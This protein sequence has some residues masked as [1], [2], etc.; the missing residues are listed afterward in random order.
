[1]P[2]SS[3]HRGIPEWAWLAGVLIVALALRLIYV[4]QV[5]RSTLVRPD[6]L[7][8]GF[9]YDWAKEIAS[10]NWLGHAPFVQSPLYAY[11]LA[12]L[13]KVFG[14]D[15]VRLLVV[16]A[17]AGCGTVL[18]TWYAGR[19]LL[20]PAHGL[21]AAGILA[22]YGP[23]I[24]FEGMVMKTFL[25]PPLTI[26]LVILFDRVRE[27]GAPIAAAGT[28][29]EP[30]PT[31]GAPAPAAGVPAPAGPAN[32][33]L[34]QAGATRLAGITGAVYGLATLD[35]DNFIL[36]APM[37][38]LL[39]LWLG[40]GPNRT[41]WRAAGAFT[42]GTVLVI[43]PVTL[44]N[45]IVA[46]EFVLL[47]TG[48]GE[49]FFIGNNADAN[50]LYVPPPFVRPDP[51]YEH[52]DF[53]SRASE[54]AGRPL[55]PMQSSWFWFRQ[56]MAFI[57]EHPLAWA[58]LL[59][60]KGVHFWN[61]YELPDNLNY[62][63]LQQFSPLLG[64][65]NAR[66]PPRGW[67]TLAL[68]LGAGRWAESRLHFYATF[69]T[70]APLGL[71]G[72]WLTRRGWRRLVPLYVLLFGYMGT[73]LLFFN[74]SRFRVPVVPI[75]ALFAAESL[76]VLGGG[77]RRA[78]RFALALL[79][80]SGDLVER[81]RALRP[82]ARQVAT[83]GL[84]AV[85]LLGLNLEL[86]RG[87]VP[88]IEEALLLGNAYYAEGQ[89]ETA[90][91]HYS[92][93]LALLGEG[94]PAGEQYL[95]LRHPGIDLAAL[96]EE[97][98]A[99]AVARGPQFKGMH[100]GIHHGI[101]IAL[102]QQASALLEAGDR[103]RAMPLLDQAIGQ[104]AE[105]LK[106]APAYLLSHRKIARAHALKGDNAGAIEW[107]RRAADLWPDD[108]ETRFELAELLHQG[109]DQRGALRQLDEA[110]A[111]NKSMDDVQLARM[112]VYRGLVFLRGL[113]EPGKALYAFERA[114]E[115]DPRVAQADELRRTVLELRARGLHPV[116]DEPG[117]APVPAR[118]PATGGAPHSPAG[119]GT[120]PG[121]AGATPGPSGG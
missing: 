95:R 87:V 13:M 78:G 36:M 55:S 83:G 118:P 73:V 94:G 44:R 90:L 52:A 39:A 86:P 53:V 22:I 6:D 110:R 108:L 1:V 97:L 23:F 80:R 107:L 81:A 31:G 91:R 77:L 35:R 76:A 43:A 49:V 96:K 30:T 68:P 3:K 109:G 105:A 65:L 111:Y 70:L 93:G 84:F 112:H 59:W 14:D 117:G 54:I 28:A 74:F 18:L 51:K 32:A 11:L 42:L 45:W 67:P 114:L 24:F 37:L 15:V 38:A 26:L 7:D 12:L 101:G 89:P 63:I 20:G 115:I 69:G 47:T 27:R 48:G 56:G 71:L 85:V 33:A 58:R 120:D 8:P 102:V 16:Q 10:G 40:G 116:A 21:L 98:E 88:A 92:T 79:K 4:F 34:A 29:A 57:A 50:G 75:L 5:G 46:K 106:L 82:G 121:A 113:N 119:S 9:Y 17:I 60:R 72:I 62:D 100:I 64:S 104:F 61:Y 25:S 41:G 99:E 2:E 66:L 19:R 103:A